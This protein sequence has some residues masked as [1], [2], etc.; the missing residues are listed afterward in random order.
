M[1]FD[2]FNTFPAITQQQSGFS[3][4]LPHIGAVWKKV[5]L[6]IKNR[7]RYNVE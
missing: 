1:V 2:I 7:I 6:A 4:I 3:R 5:V